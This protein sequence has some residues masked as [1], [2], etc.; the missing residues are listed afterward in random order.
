M[1]LLVPGDAHQPRLLSRL[2]PV[3]SRRMRERAAAN[4]FVD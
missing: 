2:V 1:C 4:A 3:L